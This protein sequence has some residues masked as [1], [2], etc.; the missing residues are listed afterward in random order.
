MG[1]AKGCALIP[2]R[3]ELTMSLEHSIKAAAKDAEGRLQAAAGALSGDEAMHAQ[4]EAKQVNFNM[5][6]PAF[7]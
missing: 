7:S 5:V 2:A 3:C 1:A 4:G 6:H